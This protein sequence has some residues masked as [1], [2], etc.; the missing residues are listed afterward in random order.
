MIPVQLYSPS[1]IGSIW[2]RNC[3]ALLE[4]LVIDIRRDG[5]LQAPDRPASY[6]MVDRAYSLEAI[7][8]DATA[9]LAYDL[10]STME[11]SLPTIQGPPRREC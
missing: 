2:Y 9:C 7:A 6:A 3:P 5:R 1:S 4:V 11:K 8:S 10:E